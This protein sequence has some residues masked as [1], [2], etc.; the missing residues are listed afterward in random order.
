MC[1]KKFLF[2]FT[3]M[4]I[5]GM[6]K[7]SFAMMCGSN[8][9]HGEHGQAAQSNDNGHSRE[10]MS[11]TKFSSEK[12]IDAGNKICPVSGEKIDENSKTVYEYDG[13]IY[14]FCCPSCIDAFKKAPDKYI[15]KVDEEFKRTTE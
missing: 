8:S 1:T 13:K 12:A 5:V 3:V 11:E 15:E 14:N 7:I 4:F 2:L 10:A 6:S 9:E